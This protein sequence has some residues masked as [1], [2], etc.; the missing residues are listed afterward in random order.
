MQFTCLYKNCKL[1]PKMEIPR[2]PGGRLNVESISVFLDSNL[3]K[4]TPA[5]KIKKYSNIVAK[6]VQ[7]RRFFPQNISKYCKYRIGARDFI[8]HRVVT[9]I[10]TWSKK[11]TIAID[12]DVISPPRLIARKIILY[13]RPIS[14]LTKG[15]RNVGKTFRALMSTLIYPIPKVPNR[16]CLFERCVLKLN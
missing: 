1:S 2:W 14:F 9:K 11:A 13:L 7:K 15:H 16:V 6:C 5:I 10:Y 3:Y 12:A 4:S 8:P